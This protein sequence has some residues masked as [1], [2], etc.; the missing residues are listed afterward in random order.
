MIRQL[1]LLI[2]NL[3]RQTPSRKKKKIITNKVC[4]EHKNLYHNLRDYMER[5]KNLFSVCNVESLYLFHRE[6][7]SE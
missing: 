7:I 5:N 3:S 4:N 1:K 2:N 6:F